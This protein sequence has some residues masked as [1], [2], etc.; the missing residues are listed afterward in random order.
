MKKKQQPSQLHDG[1]YMGKKNNQIN[2]LND[3]YEK[4]P[5]QQHRDWDLWINKTKPMTRRMKSGGKNN[6]INTAMEEIW[7]KQKTKNKISTICE[8]VLFPNLSLATRSLSK[9]IILGSQWRP[10]N[11]VTSESLTRA[12]TMESWRR[13]FRD[14]AELRWSLLE[15]CMVD[16]EE[17]DT[18]EEMFMIILYTLMNLRTKK[19]YLSYT[20]YYT[21]SSW[22]TL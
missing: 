13:W 16:V 10:W 12:T 2:N 6:E 20:N 17:E 1:W 8:C 15:A 21:R 14:I 4:K 7:V 3:I 19:I 22:P 5:N 18:M 11:W 9:V